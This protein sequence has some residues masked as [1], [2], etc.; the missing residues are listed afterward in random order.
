MRIEGLSHT[1]KVPQGNTRT[2][3]ARAKKPAGGDDV[4]EISRDAQEISD[5]AAKITD[6]GETGMSPRL[7]EVK[8]KVDS[9]FFNSRE[10]L[11]AVAGALQDADPI[12]D[13][14]GEIKTVQTAKRQLEDVPDVRPERVQEAKLKVEQN[15]FFDREVEQQTAEN[16]LN[17][18]I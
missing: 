4:V 3:S 14:V 1:P 12:A 11:E 9:G 18:M 13:V 15:V 7:E 8:A 10:R 6:A 2:D 16:I 17:E 5:L